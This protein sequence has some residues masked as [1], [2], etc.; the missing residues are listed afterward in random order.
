MEMEFNSSSDILFDNIVEQIINKN[1][2]SY[3]CDIRK[4]KND[5][6]THVKF[7]EL[8]VDGE[9]SESFMTNLS[10]DNLTGKKIKFYVNSL[11][12]K[13]INNRPY[14]LIKIYEFLNENT[15]IKNSQLLFNLCSNSYKIITSTKEVIYGKYLYTL[16]L[17]VKEIKEK[18][19][20]YK[21]QLED[22]NMNPIII[23][24]LENFELEANKI[25]CFHGYIYNSSNFKLERTH[26]SHIE[27]LSSS[28]LRIYNSEDIFESKINSLLNFK[29]KVK[30]LNIT[31]EVIN[32]EDE[33]KKNYKINATY[34]LI[35]QISLS[36]E[37]K[38]YNFIKKSNEEFIFS[39]FSFIEAKEQ[40]FVEFYFP[41]Y[42]LEEKYYNKIRI[43]D[44][45]FDINNKYIKIKVDDEDKRN[46]FL[47]KIIFERIIEKKCIGSY[48]F[49]LELNKGK[50][51]SLNSSTEKGG[52]SYEFYIQSINEI[53][54][55]ENLVVKL[56]EK[57][58]IL[59]NPDKNGNKLK[60][61][62]TIINFPKQDV[63]SILG[64]SIEN[65][66]KDDN[67]NDNDND[68]YKYLLLIDSNNKKTLKQF[69]KIEPENKKKNFYVSEKLENELEKASAQCHINFIE[70]ID[71]KLYN[72]DKSNI[73]IFVDL[74]YELFNGFMNYKFENT[75]K[76]Y[77]VIKDIVSFSLNYFE[78]ILLGKYYSFRK[79]YEILLDSMLNLEY[80]D[81]IKILISFMVKVMNSIEDK[82]IYYDMFHLIDID[83]SNS[84]EDFPYVKDAFD[85]FYKIIDNLQEDCPLFQTIYQFN[86]IICKDVISGEEQHSGSILNV[87][88]IKLELVKNI[89]RFMFLSEKSFNH[90]DENANFEKTGLLLTC[91]IFS[92]SENEIEILDENNF[93]RAT[94]IILFLL[95]HECLG[96]QKKNINNGNI[97]TTRKHYK[98]D[99]QDF[100]FSTA[101]TGNALEILLTGKIVNKK[102]LMNSMNSEKL[103]DPKLYTGKD[104]I[105]LQ[106]I[107]SWIEKDNIIKKNGINNLHE[108]NSLDEN[109]IQSKIK[110][111]LRKKNEHLMYSELFQLYSEIKDEQKEELKDDEDYQR[112]LKIY[113]RKHQKPSEYLKKEDLLAIRFGK[114][115]YPFS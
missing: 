65:N 91:N 36:A 33:N 51:Y 5:Y 62:F 72:I 87:N 77:K 69:K 53:N 28:I 10:N 52:F 49:T 57:N 97:V 79:N 80:I 78:K 9:K 24:Q 114:K 113:E 106:Q 61:R 67:D 82:K 34:H 22:L 71:E 15:D 102:Y 90:C 68:N 48:K 84:Y 64:L 7:I 111:K 27:E 70:N 76:Q 1:N 42:D 29:G 75:K 45:Y 60:E 18:T 25:Y 59:K 50:T 107:Y 115:K 99:F 46:I 11:T 83:N 2:K 94:S 95:L 74:M 81:R 96:H 103:L 21:L 13:I 19:Q 100:S 98:N 23:D 41:L 35:K 108:E 8:Y 37:C 14:F 43:N 47:E 58:L 31:D 40:T 17:K 38:F 85:I 105:K 92:F 104:F 73:K 26:I 54:L 32:V 39:N 12:I 44:K 6:D 88:D 30:S 4:E 86:N 16:I 101:D 93:K 110:P 109:T 66:I 112:F 3:E 56:K 55:P 89:N 20:K 63:K